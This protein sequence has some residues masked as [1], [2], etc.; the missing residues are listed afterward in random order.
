MNN[1]ELKQLEEKLNVYYQ[2]HPELEKPNFYC[3]DCGKFLVYDDADIHFNKRVN[4]NN[5]NEIIHTGQTFLSTR[6]YNGHI[7]HLCR[8]KECVGKKYDTVYTR[9][10]IY[11]C[12]FAQDI[13]YA[14]GISDEDFSQYTK[15]RQAITKDSMIKKYGEEKGLEK[16]NSYCQK[17]AITNTFEYKKEKY[18]M[19][20]KEFKEF[21]KS[22]ACTKE[23]FIKRYGEEVGIKKW[24]E[25]CERQRYTTSLEYFIKEYGEKSGKEKYEQFDHGRTTFG[26]ASKIAD[27]FFN[28]LIKNKI[29]ENHEIYFNNHPIEYC[30]NGYRLDFYD[31]T[32]NLVIEFYGDL[33]HRNPKMFNANDLV[34][35]IFNTNEKYLVKEVWERDEIRKNNIINALNCNFLIIWESEI[36]KSEKKK[37]KTIDKIVNIIKNQELKNNGN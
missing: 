26:G 35:N 5:K 28:D 7:Y 24:D 15:A 32:L 2:N 11:S 31:K 36:K 21:N 37:Q 3:K 14:Y 4:K 34:T 19:S 12:K 25:Y 30:V 27:N 33:W 6:E 22:R 17:Q 18:G 1:D 23:L 8:C 10:A 9:K 16:W 29:F 20:E 13:K